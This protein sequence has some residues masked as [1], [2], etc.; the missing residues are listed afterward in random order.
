MAAANFI[1]MQ[2]A[3]E[4]LSGIWGLAI[5]TTCVLWVIQSIITIV[6]V[7]GTIVYLLILPAFLLGQALFYLSISRRLDP[8][9]EQIFDGFKNFST[10]FVTVLVAQIMIILWTLCFII[11]G[12]IAS[13]SYSQITYILADNPNIKPMDAL[14]KSKA[15][16]DGH[17]MQLFLLHLRFLGWALLSVFT[18][19][20]GLLWLIPWFHVSSAKFYDEINPD[21]EENEEREIID[22]L[23]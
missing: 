2:K 12:I 6:P 3:K 1:I 10:A 21:R 16:M 5:G 18:L 23:I 20:I 4:T 14:R 9:L 8:R 17:K 22:H 15:M 13:Y 7:L 19:F 11:P